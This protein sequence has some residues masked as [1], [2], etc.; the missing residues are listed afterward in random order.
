[1]K[2][3]ILGAIRIR[4][5]SLKATI[6]KQAK[7]KKQLYPKYQPLKVPFTKEMR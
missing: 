4:I 2:G 6:E 1:M 5:R 3:V 7:N